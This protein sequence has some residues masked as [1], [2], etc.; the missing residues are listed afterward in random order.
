M[1]PE[2]IGKKVTDQI[3]S[4]RGGQLVIPRHM[5]IAAGLRGM[6]NWMQEFSRDVAVGGVASQFPDGIKS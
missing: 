6:S 4:C 5:G 1:K 2:L 3:F